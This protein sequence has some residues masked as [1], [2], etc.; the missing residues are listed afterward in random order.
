MASSISENK[1]PDSGSGPDTGVAEVL[2]SVFRRHGEVAAAAMLPEVLVSST[3]TPCLA[4]L[5]RSLE[6]AGAWRVLVPLWCEIIRRLATDP[7]DREVRAYFFNDL[8][9]FLL[10]AGDPRCTQCFLSALRL[11][12]QDGRRVRTLARLG[13]AYCLMFQDLAR[14][15]RFYRAALSLGEATGYCPIPMNR[16]EWRVEEFELYLR[17]LGQEFGARRRQGQAMGMVYADLL[18]GTVIPGV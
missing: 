6:T 8:G 14:A 2:E 16:A 1:K 5:A 12:R 13:N 3:P 18:R 4:R 10:M 11:T 15:A 9:T 17:G 7:A